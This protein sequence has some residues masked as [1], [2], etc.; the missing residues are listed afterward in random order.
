VFGGKQLSRVAA[1]LL[2]GA[3]A[4]MTIMPAA[5]AQEEGRKTR[6]KV[7]PVYPELARKMNVVG[8]VK[9]EVTITPA[10]V[11]K[12]TKVVGGHPLL[13]DSALDALK[14]WRFESA[15]DETTQIV[16]FNFG[17]KTN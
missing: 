3:M 16:V 10:G 17:Q 11:V 15:G 2:A 5:F 6:N 1:G 14:K 9:I 4:F 7:V 12:T 8:S 13:V